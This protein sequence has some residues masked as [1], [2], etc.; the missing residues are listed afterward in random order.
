MGG[1]ENL[2]EYE[3][4]GFIDDEEQQNYEEDEGEEEEVQEEAR[5]PT[6]EEM[7]FLEVRQKIKDTMRR[8]MNQENPSDTDNSQERKKHNFGSFFGPSEPSIAQRVIRE[9]KS[10][11][12]AAKVLNPQHSLQRQK[13]P[14]LANAASKPGA[15]EQPRKAVSKQ[16]HKAMILKNARDYSFLHSEDAELPAATKVPPPQTSS[17]PNSESAQLMSKVPKSGSS[18]TSR[19]VLDGCKQRLP[20]SAGHRMQSKQEQHKPTPGVRLDST[21]VNHRKQQSGST[22]KEPGRNQGTKGLP[23]KSSIQVKPST[24][25]KFSVPDRSLA[26]TT[27]RNV[28]LAIAKRPPSDM[29]KKVLPRSHPP[30]PGLEKPLPKPQLSS[31]GVQRAPSKLHPQEQR[32]ELDRSRMTLKQ[33]IPCSAARKVKTPKQL[34]CCPPAPKDRRRKRSMIPDPDDFQQ[35][36]RNMFGYNP[37][38]YGDDGDDS[39][40]EVG[41]QDIMREEKRSAK[42]AAKEDERERILIEKEEQEERM[43]KKR[44]MSSQKTLL[45]N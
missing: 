26:P 17:A 27:D 7:D 41:F 2:D 22:G 16:K 44:K 38:K 31:S 15:S 40:M 33:Q 39:D 43:R 18:T 1:Y 42:I 11:N 4:D 37:S 34:P 24:L 20:A 13:S 35:E 19:Q 6:K 30:M 23:S 14:A 21:S 25:N 32:K 36:I 3:D 10:L 29:R 5:K 9:S 8:K 45:A 28:S 12:L